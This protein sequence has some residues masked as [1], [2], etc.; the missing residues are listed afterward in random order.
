MSGTLAYEQQTFYRGE[1][2]VHVLKGSRLKPGVHATLTKASGKGGRWI[3]AVNGTPVES[4]DHETRA[5]ADAALRRVL[6]RM[7]W[8]APRGRKWTP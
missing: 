4:R 3:A 8:L 6:I 7:D 2:I 1:P 5:S